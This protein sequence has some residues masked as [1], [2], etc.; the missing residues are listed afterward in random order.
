FG[1]LDHSGK[2]VIPPTFTLAWDFSEGRAVVRTNGFQKGYIDKS[3]R[4]VVKPQFDSASDFSEGLASVGY[5]GPNGRFGYIDSN[6]TVVVPIQFV[7]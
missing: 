6:G 3:G 1:F 5:Y 2:I 7:S 4:T